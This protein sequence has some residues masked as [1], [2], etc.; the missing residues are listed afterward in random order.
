MRVGR[1]LPSMLGKIFWVL[2]LLWTLHIE[3]EARGVFWNG[4]TFAEEETPSLPSWIH[5]QDSGWIGQVFWFPCSMVARNVVVPF[6]FSQ[7]GS[8]MLRYSSLSEWFYIWCNVFVKS[9]LKWFHFL[10]EWSYIRCNVFVKPELKL[11]SITLN[12]L[13]IVVMHRFNS[14]WIQ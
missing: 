13:G 2:L 4:N 14:V 3:C 10:F 1:M 11:C 7:A 6:V 8:N 5:G 9:E 12:Y